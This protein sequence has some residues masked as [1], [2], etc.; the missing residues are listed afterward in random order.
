MTTRTG[1]MGAKWTRDKIKKKITRERR[2]R[3]KDIKTKIY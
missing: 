2:K 1:T 3:N